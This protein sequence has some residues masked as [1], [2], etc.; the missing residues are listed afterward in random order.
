MSFAIRY[1]DICPSVCPPIRHVVEVG[2]PFPSSMKTLTTQGPPNSVCFAATAGQLQYGDS[3]SSDRTDTSESLLSPVLV[4]PARW[5]TASP[6]RLIY[7]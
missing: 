6:N 3:R 1:E 5:L 2:Y 4:H 7:C